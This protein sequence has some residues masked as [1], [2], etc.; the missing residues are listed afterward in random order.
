MNAGDVVEVKIDKIGI[1]RNFVVG[2]E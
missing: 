2:Q 1:L